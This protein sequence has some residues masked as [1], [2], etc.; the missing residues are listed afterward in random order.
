MKKL[1]KTKNYMKK[2]KDRGHNKKLKW[3]GHNKGRGRN[4]SS[5]FRALDFTVSLSLSPT[6]RHGTRSDQT[7][8]S[9]SNPPEEA[10]TKGSCFTS[11][12]NNNYTDHEARLFD[13]R[14]PPGPPRRSPPARLVP[15]ACHPRCTHL[16]NIGQGNYHKR[17]TFPFRIHIFQLL[18]SISVIL[19]Y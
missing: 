4:P 16:V 11:Q 14:R 2:Q 19:L 5:T 6:I 9:R 15:L 13:A 3:N 7:L 18:Y 10:S 1:T 17:L 8:N 12:Q